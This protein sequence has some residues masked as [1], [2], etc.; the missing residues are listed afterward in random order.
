MVATARVLHHVL[1]WALVAGVAV[2]VFLAG[3]GV[4]SGAAN[5]AT[6]R[7]FG[8]LLELLPILILVA[9]AV[10]RLGRRQVIMPLVIFGLFILQSVFV[11]LRESTPAVAALHPVNGFFIAYLAVQLAREAWARYR[12]GTPASVTSPAAYEAPGS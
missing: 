1:A 6:H 7:D 8:Y 3:L 5:F 2:Q 4:F 10:G 11:A 9:A 12:S